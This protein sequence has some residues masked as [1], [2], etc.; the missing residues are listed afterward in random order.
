M[1]QSKKKQSI[2]V[3]ALTGTA[4][5][6]F[7]KALGLIYAS[8]LSAMAGSDLVFYGR[9]Y[10]M[11]D[12]LLTISL[13]GIPFAIATLVAKYIA[14]DDYKTALLV[15]KISLPILSV[16]GVAL[17]ALVVLFSGNIVSFLAPDRD[18][19]YLHKFQV[20]IILI[21][22]AAITV[23]IL[24]MF[25]GFYQGLKEMK[26]YSFSQVLEQ[27]VR[28]SFLLSAGALLVYGFNQEGI[29]A[30]Y[31]AIAS[32]SVSA[33]VT[34]FYF[35]FLDRS[36]LPEIRELANK[37]ENESVPQKALFR[38]IMYI[39]LPFLAISII[40]NCG[41]LINSYIV[42]PSLQAFGYSTELA[43]TIYSMISF[44]VYKLITIPQ[45]L[46]PG[47]AIAI[48]PHIAAS[49]AIA[50]YEGIRL[51]IK[52]VL[53]S[54]S[55]LIYP[56]ILLMGL[57]AP[58]VYFVMYGGENLHLGANILQWY[59][60]LSS[61][62]II[63][64]LCSNILMALELKRVN[65]IWNVVDLVA[66]ILFIGIVT[67]NYSYPGLFL[68]YSAIYLGFI[69]LGLFI[70][71]KRYDLK[72]LPIFKTILK[73]TACLIVIFGVYYLSRFIPFDAMEQGRIFTFIWI[74]VI[75]VVAI[76]AYLVVTYLL[77]LPQEIF[78]FDLSKL[79]KGK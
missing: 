60:V 61:F 6:F 31:F 52:K 20:S 11:Y 66:L 1:T 36:H 72:L 75:S 40:G 16:I 70:I 15:R 4:G 43:D 78:D 33:L 44:N 37:Q 57:F 77:K 67:S 50:D 58:E 74:G 9:T 76:I 68:L 18:S 79:R 59:L 42:I 13:S 32:T 26:V 69:V 14:K 5:I 55:Y 24:S 63:M 45:I 21:S 2:I 56:I 28:V 3:G 17:F 10:Q 73:S 48:I 7:T 22:F 41:G 38:E 64:V 49:L 29:W 34:I 23:P 53:T 54:C 30:V 25:R 39:A 51:N 62:W 12:F 47:F 65:L 8:P 46:G 19:I 27:L 71:K 35:L